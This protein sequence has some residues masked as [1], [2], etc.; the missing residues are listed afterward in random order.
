MGLTA[1]ALNSDTPALGI[2]F[3]ENGGVSRFSWCW[4]SFSNGADPGRV[5]G[6]AACEQR[7]SI[8]PAAAQPA[9]CQVAGTRL[10][11]AH[12]VRYL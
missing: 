2:W 12:S 1:Q 6:V 11:S 7:A 5:G 10:L 9:G 8:A 3:G 4:F